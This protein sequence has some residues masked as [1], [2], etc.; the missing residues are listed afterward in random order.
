VDSSLGALAD[1]IGVPNDIGIA[2]EAALAYLALLDRV[3][4][5]RVVTND[6]VEGLA[7]VARLWQIPSAAAAALH[8]EYLSD[9]WEL[10]WA[11][12]I[13]TPAERRDL[14]ML[15]ELLGVPLED[16]APH[17]RRRTASFAAVASEF[18]GR[19]ICFTGESVCSMDGAEFDRATQEELA[20]E[21][22]LLIKQGVS[23]KLDIL[24]LAD[25]DSQ[26]AKARKA[27]ELGVRMM[28]EAVFW[29]ALGVPID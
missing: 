1:R 4:E 20:A 16:H 23:S 15:A 24:V 2:D 26:S 17:P 12:G 18:A 19:S 3:L 10:A 14:R 22:G 6:E 13:I 21:R 29:R 8:H 5:D 9:A 11:D 27:R 7:E 25:P 28:A